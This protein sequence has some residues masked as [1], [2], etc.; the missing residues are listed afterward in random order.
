MIVGLPDSSL[1]F[2]LY[3]LQYKD[4][5][6]RR[7]DYER[8]GDGMRTDETKEQKMLVISLII[9]IFAIITHNP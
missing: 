4:T 9:S 3:H 2:V 8:D 6:A 1:S 5:T 7:R